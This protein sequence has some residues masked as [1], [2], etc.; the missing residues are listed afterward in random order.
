MYPGGPGVTHNIDSLLPILAKKLAR[1]ENDND[2][3]YLV[4]RL[5]KETTGVMMLAR[6]EHMLRRLQAMFRNRKVIKKYW[7]ITVG[8]PDPPSGVVDMPIAEAGEID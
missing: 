5:D 3:L 8:V 1:K 2:T 4:H 6:T 7:T